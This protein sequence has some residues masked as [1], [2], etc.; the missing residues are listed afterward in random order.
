MRLMD[1]E[2]GLVR[3]G[4]PPLR[5]SES[6]LRDWTDARALAIPIGGACGAGYYRRSAH[7]WFGGG[8]FPVWLWGLGLAAVKAETEVVGSSDRPAADLASPLQVKVR[9]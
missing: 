7:C 4:Q 6:L 9:P 1:A 2:S 5:R 8:P 3:K